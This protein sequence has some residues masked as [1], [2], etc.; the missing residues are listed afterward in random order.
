MVEC[1]RLRIECENECVLHSLPDFPLFPKELSSLTC[2]ART[3]AGT[4]CK[5]KSLFRSGR[6][7][8][9]GGL[10]TGPKS[11]AGIGQ[12][13]VNLRKAWAAQKRRREKAKS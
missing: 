9:H 1:E 11:K 8:W 6:C 10:S 2:G 4:P 7:K 3:R 5:Q 12:A 13:K